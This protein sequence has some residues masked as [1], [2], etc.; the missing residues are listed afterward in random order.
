MKRRELLA[1]FGA[2]ATVR[3][4]PSTTQATQV[5]DGRTAEAAMAS[6]AVDGYERAWIDVGDVVMAAAEESAEHAA[7]DAGRQVPQASVEQ[8]RSDGAAAALGGQIR[9][10]AAQSASGMLPS[11]PGTQHPGI[12]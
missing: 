12:E 10:F 7:A 6:D 11:G 8:V 2:A 3:Y 9:S 1:A 4:G 5:D